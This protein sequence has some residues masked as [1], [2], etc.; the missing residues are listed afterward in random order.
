[1]SERTLHVLV[2]A[3]EKTCGTCPSCDV[4][5]PHSDGHSYAVCLSFGSQLETVWLDDGSRDRD[6]LAACLSAEARA[7]KAAAVVEAARRVVPPL[8][9]SHDDIA[10]L[11]PAL[12]DLAVVALLTGALAVTADEEPAIA[13]NRASD[14]I[15]KI[16]ERM[17]RPEMQD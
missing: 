15:R 2:D 16:R 11:Y 8:L 17:D 6:R 3:E 4:S 9:A 1:M 12:A 13:V 14:Q 5:N 10:T 7:K